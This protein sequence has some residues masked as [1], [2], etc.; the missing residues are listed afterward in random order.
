MRKRILAMTALT[1]LVGGATRAPPPPNGAETFAHGEFGAVNFQ[2]LNSVAVPWK[3]TTAALLLDD[4]QGGGV[5]RAHLRRRME[6]FG[7]LWPDRLRGAPASVTPKQDRPL[8]MSVGAV[9]PGLPPVKVTVGNLGCAACHSGPTYAA[10][11]APLHRDAWLGAPN[12]SL[13][14]ESYTRAVTKALK[15][16]LRDEDKLLKAVKTLY[17]ETDG[18]EMASLR[19][20]VIPLAKQ[21][22]NKLADGQSPLPFI[23]GSP[24]LT[25][26]VAALKLQ[27]KTGLEAHEAGFTS[28]PDLADRG[29]RT[30][31]LY[32][33]AYTPLN[34]VRW[35]A[36]TRADVTPAHRDRLAAIASFFTV[37]SMGQAPK[38]AH[39]HQS[40]A[41]AAM[42]WLETRRPQAFPGSIDA[43]LAARGADVFAKTCS[44]CHGDYDGPPERPRLAN[45]PNWHGMVGTDPARAEAFTPA[46]AR[47]VAQS[48]YRD[49]MSAKP[50]GEYAA[51]LL[52]GVWASAPY[53]HNG[54][55][56]TLEQLML[57]EPRAE[58]FE[59]GGHRLDLRAVGVAGATAGDGVRR[60]P[61]G[62]KPW[63]RPAVYDTRQ[64]GRSNK[65]H[66]AQ[67]SDI[68]VADRWALIEY[69][70][71][72]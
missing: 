53:L 38:A 17:P 63:A 27:G 41:K 7:F 70:K 72:L 13:D 51:P 57:L 59:V 32:D 16:R 20:A 33:G 15:T 10:D 54:S 67:F 55:V 47:Y 65:G 40:E 31:L 71:R 62:Y 43:S 14:L 30:A 34:E 56:P 21:R 28:V 25:N 45:F 29:F 49:V 18:W 1:L 9:T 60:Y 61:A 66:E 4:P 44:R 48:P 5:D 19:W 26:G 23:N 42:A 3:L 12:T 69:L 52:S 36:M 50:T 39:G 2:A 46:L 64:P 24:G 22:L 58:R 11:G 8:G 37:P 6:S 68:P 35:R